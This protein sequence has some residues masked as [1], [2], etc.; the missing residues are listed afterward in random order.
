MSVKGNSYRTSPVRRGKFIVNRLLCQSVPPPPPNVVP[1]L[2]PPDP[3]KT[4]REQMAMH[5]DNPVCA[6][7][8]DRMDN[9]GFAFEHFDG[10]GNYRETENDRAI[11][12][13]GSTQLDGATLQFRDATE[14]VGALAKSPEVQACFARQ[15]LRYALDRFEQDE[16]SAAVDRLV[17]SYANEGLDT[18]KL[19]VDITREMPFSHRALAEGEEFE[20]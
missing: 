7:C 12:A 11:D 2:P 20:P 13:S 9:L 18:R 10:A 6:S 1:D 3:T 8:H 5:R 19:L 17:K 15:W 16:D 14:L 4:L